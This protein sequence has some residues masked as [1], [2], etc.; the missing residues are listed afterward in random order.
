VREATELKIELDQTGD[1]RVVGRLLSPRGVARPFDGW[2]ALIAALDTEL[3][4]PR[5]DPAT[6]GMWNPRGDSGHL[7]GT[8]TA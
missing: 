2:L 7:D 8:E 4:P 3:T 6:A 1:D 5:S